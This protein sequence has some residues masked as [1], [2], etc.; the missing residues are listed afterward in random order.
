MIG[1][2]HTTGLFCRVLFA[3]LLLAL[4]PAAARAEKLVFTNM[5]GSPIVLQGSCVVQG[6]VRRGPLVA[7]KNGDVAVVALPGNKVISI[8]DPK[9]PNALLFQTPIPGGNDDIAFAIKLDPKTGKV[10]LELVKPMR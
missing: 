5:T 9:P 1:P 8:Y 6:A 7:M 10:A 4:A 2:L 3:L